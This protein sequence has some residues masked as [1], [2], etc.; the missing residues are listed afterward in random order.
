MAGAWM[1]ITLL[2]L[3]PNLILINLNDELRL[4]KLTH[5]DSHLYK[6]F[7][8]NSTTEKDP[9]FKK[10]QD[11]ESIILP[12]NPVKLD[13]HLLVNKKNHKIVVNMSIENEK[14]KENAI[15]EENVAIYP[16]NYKTKS[17]NTNQTPVIFA[18]T[19]S[20]MHDHLIQRSTSAKNYISE[21]VDES[22]NFKVDNLIVNIKRESSLIQYKNKPY[23]PKQNK[24]QV[25]SRLKPQKT[26]L[27]SEIYKYKFIHS[28][29][30]SNKVEDYF[31]KVV[32]DV[33]NNTNIIKEISNKILKIEPKQNNS[34][35]TTIDN[36]K[37]ISSAKVNNNKKKPINDH[38]KNIFITINQKVNEGHLEY[39]CKGKFNFKQ[40]YKN[41]LLAEKAS[42]S[43][44]SIE[45]YK[46]KGNKE[47]RLTPVKN[48]IA[49]QNV[50]KGL[51]D[52]LIQEAKPK[53]ID[54]TDDFFNWDIE[55]N[56][57]FLKL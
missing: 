4:V 22:L 55:G 27:E 30:D 26:D 32:D 53:A 52:C 36:P 41:E 20:N 16:I 54:E 24:P 12:S 51:K 42:T 40:K 2:I 46:I 39:L 8:L 48:K 31:A 45:E 17:R 34:K 25:S 37:S 28:I 29:S 11:S 23:N 1:K 57:S 14:E 15:K 9:F 18:N 44:L 33:K 10:S 56:I 5:L 3:K 38:Q 6:L 49:L 47:K 50:N 43:L 19:M 13:S 21:E 7:L 35:L